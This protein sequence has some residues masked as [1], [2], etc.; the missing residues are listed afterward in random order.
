MATPATGTTNLA[1]NRFL[2]AQ[3]ARAT[4]L[5]SFIR[6]SLASCRVRPLRHDDRVPTISEFYG[7]V[8]EMYFVDHPPPHFHARCRSELMANWDR[9][10]AGRPTESVDPLR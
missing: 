7:I 10:S 5:S 3:R 4:A 8:I 2:G 6:A 9:A 1:G